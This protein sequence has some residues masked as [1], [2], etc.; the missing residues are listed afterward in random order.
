M[1]KNTQPT[2]IDVFAGC[3]G[4]SLGLMNAGW[5]GLF[6][7]ERDAF[8]FDTLT[9]NLSNP[10]KQVGMKWPPWLPKKPISIEDFVI[11]YHDEIRKM[12]GKVDLLAGGP[13][14]QGFSTYGRRRH[15]D[16]R[17]QMFRHYVSL[18]QLLKPRAILIE[19]VRG[20]MVTFSKKRLKS[21]KEQLGVAYSEL[22]REAL[23]GDY[24]IQTAIVRA[25]DF[26]VPQI[27]PRFIVFG[28]R[29]EE[30][31]EAVNPEFEPFDRLEQIRIG[32]L[33]R[34][35]LPTDRAVNAKEALSDLK[36]VSCRLHACDE[37]RGYMQGS[38]GIQ[39]SS[40]QQLMH[41]SLNGQKADSH[42][43]AKH[44]PSTVK[45]FTWLLDNC[46]RGKKLRTED[47]GTYATK[48]H[49]TCILCPDSPSHTVTTLPDD[50]LHYSQPRILTVREMARLQ[51]FPDW[52][53]FK[54]KYTTGGHLRTKQCPR[55]TQV[56]NAVPP[57]MAEALGEALISSLRGREL[58]PNRT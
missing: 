16:P 28:L 14:C 32:F 20:I 43:F 41:G 51:S 49:S 35:G 25:K 5:R 42:R 57:L 47:M 27:R 8:A 45:R 56:G 21:G 48:K 58:T 7:I 24:H 50:L 34:K 18:V 19:N 36:R 22:I 53:E 15:D 30:D 1:S 11:G 17:N 52:F 13:P 39:E 12:Q 29:R 33:S 46:E 23:E 31:F 26:G 44:Q 55:Y 3:G 10:R 40:Y 38:F 37:S 9:H 2:F 6:A 4:L 54:G